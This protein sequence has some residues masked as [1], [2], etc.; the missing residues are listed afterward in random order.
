MI[1]NK[2]SAREQY[3]SQKEEFGEYAR[4]ILDLCPILKGHLLDIGCGL[5]WVV[6]EAKNRGLCATGIDL[7]TD[8]VNFGKKYLKVD[9]QAIS[10]EKFKTKEKFDVITLNHVLEHIENPSNFLSKIKSLLKKDGFFIVACPNIRSLM[11]CIF[12]SRW[13]GLCPEEHIWQFTPKSLSDLLI[14]NGFKIEKIKINNMGY[15]IN[16]WKGIIFF[17]ILNLGKLTGFGDQVMIVARQK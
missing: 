16:G 2:Y 8:Y 4:E 14:S 1:D 10:L 9:L 11:Y 6:K 5:G 7:K 17:V 12:R 3:E 15:H 13:Y